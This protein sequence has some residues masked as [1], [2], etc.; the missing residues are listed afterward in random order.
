VRG[1]MFTERW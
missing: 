1:H